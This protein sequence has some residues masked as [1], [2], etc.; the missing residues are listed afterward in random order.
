MVKPLSQLS[1]DLII[2]FLKPLFVLVVVLRSVKFGTTFF[3]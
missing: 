2:L 1:T 3:I